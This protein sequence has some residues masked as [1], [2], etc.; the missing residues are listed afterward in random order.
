M[1]DE[2]ADSVRDLWYLCAHD[3][4]PI[5]DEIPQGRPGKKGN[6]PISDN[7][8]GFVAWI[9]RASAEE[10]DRMEVSDD[11]LGEAEVPP[12]TNGIRYRW[13]TRRSKVYL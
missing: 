3:D 5:R 8:V 9:E 13:I 2:M 4:C 12:E 7:A 11:E 1:V 6:Q 10:P